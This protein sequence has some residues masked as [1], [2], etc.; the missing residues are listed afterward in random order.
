MIIPARL[1]LGQMGFQCIG[2]FLFNDLVIANPDLKRLEKASENRSSQKVEEKGR[3]SPVSHS[4]VVK[5][6]V[7]ALIP[8]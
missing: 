2:R 4:I 5:D 8:K 7:F 3:D 1:F 6:N